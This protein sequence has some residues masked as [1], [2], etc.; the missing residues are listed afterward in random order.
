MFPRPITTIKQI[1]VTSKCNLACKYCPHPK[2][3]RKKEHMVWKTFEKTLDWVRYFMEQGTQREVAI[4]GIGEAL[5]HPGFVEMVKR[6]RI[7]IGWSNPITFSTNG[8]LLTDELCIALKPFEPR[9]FVS[10]HRPEKAG[11]AI[12]VAKKYGLYATHN[13]AFA[14]DSMNWAGTVDWYVSTHSIPSRRGHNDLLHGLREVGI[15]RE[16]VYGSS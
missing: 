5:M 6:I 16:C 8:I 1:E 13:D 10:L 2:M 15:N 7:V 14:T 11:K 3:K 9:I 4:T 12:E